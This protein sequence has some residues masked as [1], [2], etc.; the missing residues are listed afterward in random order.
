MAPVVPLYFLK[1]F[2]MKQPYTASVKKFNSICNEYTIQ[3][4]GED[5]HDFRASDADVKNYLYHLNSAHHSGLI[6]GLDSA[7]ETISKRLG[8]L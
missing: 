6:Q 8:P 5:S 7:I 2:I 4:H 3:L 1:D